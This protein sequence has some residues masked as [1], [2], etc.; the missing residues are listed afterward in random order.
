MRAA[1]GEFRA[2]RGTRGNSNSAVMFCDLK[3]T[4]RS[5]GFDASWRGEVMPIEGP[6]MGQ[7]LAWPEEAGGQVR[8]EAK[9][10]QAQAS[11]LAL[12]WL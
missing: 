12:V 10:G 7:D 9:P 3:K 2:T 5:L 11:D 8:A 6:I 1:R 4:L